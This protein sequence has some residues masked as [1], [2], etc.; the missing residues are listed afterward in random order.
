MSCLNSNIMK[1]AVVNMM[2]DV[3]GRV[4]A[5]ETRPKDTPARVKK[6]TLKDLGSLKGLTFDTK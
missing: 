1:Q 3:R 6:L 2:N 5:S 4:P